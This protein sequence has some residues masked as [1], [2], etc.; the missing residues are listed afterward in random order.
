MMQATRWLGPKRIGL[1]RTDRSPR[2][3]AVLSGALALGLLNLGLTACASASYE[4]ASDGSTVY[5][6][7][8]SDA[9]KAEAREKIVQ[10]LK[11]GV[12]VYD[13]GVGDEIEIFFHIDRK[14]I[15]GH[16]VIRAADKI[17]I[18]FLGDAE[19]SRT[20]QVPPDGRISLPLIGSVM[21]AGKT[22]AALGSEIQGRYSGILTE[23]KVTVNVTESHSP[24]DDFI[25]VLGSSTKGRSLVNKVLPD[26]TIALPLL[27]ALRARG[28]T[29]KDLQHE[30][31]V[32][33]SAKGLDVFVSLVPRTLRA[34]A[35][36]VVGEVLKPGRIELDRPTT[37]A[38]AVAQA[39][40]ILTTGAARS[41][42]LLYIGDDGVQRIRSINVREV[43]DGLKLE[44]DMIVPANSIIYVPPTE[45]AQ[46]GRLM[47]A[48]VR[49]IFRFSGFG[50]GFAYLLNAPTSNN[51]DSTTIVPTPTAR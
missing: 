22:P 28:R 24:L 33:Y 2:R 30:I 8:L 10:K 11:R 6:D 16:Y 36:V 51:N 44:N 20:V 23:P 27:P 26:G 14:P 3:R 35:T 5:L 12:E 1:P 13:I 48:V 19:N 38:M 37:V 46:T 17:R 32:A 25:E 29:L 39:G 18:E 45:L 4:R 41:V 40:G 43:M 49:D 50:V 47:D 42:R 9:A 34:N 31:D 21:V 15:P 7:E